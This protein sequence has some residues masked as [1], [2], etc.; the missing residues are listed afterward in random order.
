[1]DFVLPATSSPRH[2]HVTA[3]GLTG[4]GIASLNPGSLLVAGQPQ[5]MQNWQ[6]HL[7]LPTY[8]M[9]VAGASPHHHHVVAAGAAGLG[10]LL[11]SPGNPP[12]SMAGTAPAEGP[13][14]M[15]LTSLCI[16]LAGTH[17]TFRGHCPVTAGGTAGLGFAFPNPWKPSCSAAG[18]GPAVA[19]LQT[20]QQALQWQCLSW[21]LHS[22][23][24]QPCTAS[25]SCVSF[26]SVCTIQYRLRSPR[27]FNHHHDGFDGDAGLGAFMQASCRPALRPIFCASLCM[28]DSECKAAGNPL[29]AEATFSLMPMIAM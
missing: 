10:L 6:C 20:P 18:T 27:S 5:A 16:K 21:R 17:W 23:Q 24:P 7:L 3:G 15:M 28:I 2:C 26:E 25:H 9:R 1:M 19:P 4:L 22:S 29:T 8:A 14:H 13:S 12:C 11:P